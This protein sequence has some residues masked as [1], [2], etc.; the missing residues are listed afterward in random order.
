M[1][2]KLNITKAVPG[3][4]VAVLLSACNPDNTPQEVIG[5]APVYESATADVRIKAEDP[6]AI[7]NGGK[8][9]AMNTMLYQV[10]DGLGIHVI[11]LSDPAQPKKMAFITLDG[12]HEIAIKGQY[13]YSNNYNDLVVIDIRDIN[14]VQMVKRMKNMFR[15]TNNALPPERGYFECVDPDKGT[16]VDWKKTTLY[17]PKCKY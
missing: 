5:W 8:I 12:A 10:E 7:V 15:F 3:M 13:L 4:L 6:R 1:S 16:V 2:I 14:N 11:D 9:Y 17:S